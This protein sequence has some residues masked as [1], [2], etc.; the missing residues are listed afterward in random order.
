MT[1]SP[2]SAVASGP[3]CAMCGNPRGS[4]TI[5]ANGVP[6]C[7]SCSMRLRHELDQE[8]SWNN[9]PLAL[10]GG[11]GGAAAGA[12]VWAAIG[13][14]TNMEV[15]YVAVLVGFL[16]GFGVKLGA[17]KS[18]GQGLQLLAA[19]LAVGGLVLAKYFIFAWMVSQAS[20]GQG[21]PIAWYD[22]RLIPLFPRMIT[23]L[24][25]PF[26][27]L[28]LFIAISAAYRV[29]TPTRVTLTQA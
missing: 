18:R 1:E 2:A 25:S 6:I 14:A 5:L 13:V 24:M 16:T 22:P 20:A 29:P 28:W 26:D 3:N 12:G 8:G 10:L 23:A 27:L 9:F 11:I 15:G 19:L 17:G 21:S 4:E 7:G